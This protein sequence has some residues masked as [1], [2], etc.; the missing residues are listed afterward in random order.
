MNVTKSNILLNNTNILQLAPINEQFA[1]KRLFDCTS[2]DDELFCVE[3]L[4]KRFRPIAFALF[5]FN[6]QKSF[7]YISNF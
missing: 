7:L 3:A 1:L 4:L 2:V 6:F 5:L